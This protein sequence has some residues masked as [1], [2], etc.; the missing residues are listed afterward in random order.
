MCL[1]AACRSCDRV[2]VHTEACVE[3]TVDETSVIESVCYYQTGNH[4][5]LGQ[6][7]TYI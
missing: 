5:D 7:N 3:T 6:M 4:Q 2:K 1:P